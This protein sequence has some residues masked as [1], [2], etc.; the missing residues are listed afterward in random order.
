MG[1]TFGGFADK[2]RRRALDSGATAWQDPQQR[3]S[4]LRFL[5][6]A[7]ARL[8]PSHPPPHPASLPIRPEMLP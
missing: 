2:T 4:R 7:S 5:R 8:S 1:P 3:D 6:M